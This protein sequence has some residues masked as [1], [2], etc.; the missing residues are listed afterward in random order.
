MRS[1]LIMTAA[2]AVSAIASVG[3]AAR[4][5]GDS[6]TR[7]QFG[8]N[9]LK[10]SAELTA[11]QIA[12]AERSLTTLIGQKDLSG[13]SFLDIGAGSGLVSL[14]ARKLGACVRSFDFDSNSVACTT[15]LQQRYHPNDS[16]WVINQGSILDENYAKSLGTFDI[17]YAWGV[18]HHTGD[19]KKAM[20]IAS[21][22]VKPGGLFVFALYEKTPLCWAWKIEKWVYC[23]LSPKWQESAQNLYLRWMRLLLRRSFD[24]YVHNYEQ[25]NRGMTLKRDVHDWLGGYP[26][27]SIAAGHAVAIIERLGFK[28]IN[29]SALS[30]TQDT[31]DRMRNPIVQKFIQWIS[32]LGLLGAGCCEYVCRRKSA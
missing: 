21:T 27:E 29:S 24:E 3:T 16:N 6:E 2:S 11:D 12:E 25:I 13:L 28:R 7:F 26:Y 22:L 32:Q 19:L 20:R 30:Y 15:S 23:H 10:F 31:E 5:P 18:L 9:W 4:R 1:F 14:V 17:V 8:D